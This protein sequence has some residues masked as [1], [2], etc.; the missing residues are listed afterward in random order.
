MATALHV[1]YSIF[2]PIILSIIFIAELPFIIKLCYCCFRDTSDG[3]STTCP[4]NL[5][6]QHCSEVRWIT[7]LICEVMHPV[8]YLLVFTFSNVVEDNLLIHFLL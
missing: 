4:I 5:V 7:C 2:V 8:V 3:V 1:W 6:L